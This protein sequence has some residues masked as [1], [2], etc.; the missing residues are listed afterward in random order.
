MIATGD[1][2]GG[3]HCRSAC[4]KTCLE[5]EAKPG[6]RETG[7]GGRG[8]A[9]DKNDSDRTKKVDVERMRVPTPAR[10]GK[11]NQESGRRKR[12]AEGARGGA[13]KKAKGGD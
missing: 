10:I 12:E 2:T 5:R 4:T 6:E 11:Q 3:R 7:E 13:R 8:C 9:G 1:G